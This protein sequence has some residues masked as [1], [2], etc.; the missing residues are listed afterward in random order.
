MQK[1]VNAAFA[2]CLALLAG[3]G[4]PDGQAVVRRI[5]DPNSSSGQRQVIFSRSF[6]HDFEERNKAFSFFSFVKF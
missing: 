6:R 3:R 1:T 5:R 4:G 2:P